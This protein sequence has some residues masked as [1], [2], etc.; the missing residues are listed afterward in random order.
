MNAKPKILIL[1]SLIVLSFFPITKSAKA[2][3]ALLL[4]SPG[5][6]SYI[7]DSS[8][9]VELK[10]ETGEVPINASRVNIYFS[11]ENLEVLDISKEGSIFTLWP[12]EPYFSNTVGEISFTAGIPH[13]GFI[14]TGKIITITFKAKKEGMTNL[15]LGEGQVLADDGKG[16][17]ILVFLKEAK[18]FIEKERKISE[19]QPEFQPGQ[20]PP[21]PQILCLT[22]PQG[23]DWYNNNGP[24]FQWGIGP[25]ITGVSFVLDQEPQT[26]PDNIP[27]G[28]ISSKTYENLPDGLWHFHLRIENEFGWSDTAHYKIKIDTRPPL[29][30]E[31]IIDNAGDATNPQPNLYFETNDETSGI[32]YYKLKI[33]GER[34]LNLMLA[35]INP[36]PLPTQSPGQYPIIVRAV[37][38]A[39]NNV[40]TKTVLDIEP[41]PSPQIVLWPKIYLP[42]EEI[43]YIEGTALPGNEITVFLKGNE[44]IIKKWQTISSEQ[45]EWSFSTKELIKSGSYYLTAQAKDERG[46][47]SEEA[48]PKEIEVRFNGFAFGPI[49]ISFRQLSLI[50]AIILILAILIFSLLIFR[51][52]QSK[53]IL[54]K[55]TKEAKESVKTSF[56]ELRKEIEKKIEMLDSQPGFTE[57]ERRIY[58]DL[59]KS[60]EKSEE[61]ISKEIRDVEK[62]L[63]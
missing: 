13:P 61:T 6:E 28:V 47:L 35:Q 46:A 5:S 17:N 14:G 58:E 31:I 1:F 50:S 32:N 7:I 40:E 52:R 39:S 63:K 34:F 53:K 9:S 51:I 3:G 33:G 60:L 20:P 36:F 12:E 41:I 10:V 55:E 38:K 4:L 43:F 8:F 24:I 48:Q 59:K 25:E 19:L 45:G 26:T 30:F 37:D 11:P 15:T 27:E 2:Q 16:T 21:A 22:H 54:K 56:E 18:Y 23:E 44:G 49:L 29:P 57:K 42:G 62:E